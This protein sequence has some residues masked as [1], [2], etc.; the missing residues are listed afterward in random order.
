[1]KKFLYVL[2]FLG[3][4]S[5]ISCATTQADNTKKAE[6]EQNTKYFGTGVG[7]GFIGF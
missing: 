4:M 3:T 2:C 6:T 1:M 7:V 5:L